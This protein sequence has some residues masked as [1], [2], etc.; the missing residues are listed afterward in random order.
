VLM[1]VSIGVV[2][3]PV[4]VPVVVVVE[5]VEMIVIAKNKKISKA[6]YIYIYI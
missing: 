1:M 2:V 3:V 6:L 4:V 5:V